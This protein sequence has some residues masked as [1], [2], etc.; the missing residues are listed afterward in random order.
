MARDGL[1][2]T[3]ILLLPNSR[4]ETVILHQLHSDREDRPN[5]EENTP[6]QDYSLLMDHYLHHKASNTTPYW[7]PSQDDVQPGKK[8][9]LLIY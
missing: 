3:S 2:V 9:K 6:S 5:S 4:P 1:L 8:E 7:T